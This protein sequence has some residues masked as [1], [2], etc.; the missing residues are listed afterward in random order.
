MQDGDPNT[1]IYDH[2]NDGVSDNVDLDCD[3]D[4]IDNRNDWEDVN[5]NG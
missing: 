4:G 3:N 5:M 1:N 2:D